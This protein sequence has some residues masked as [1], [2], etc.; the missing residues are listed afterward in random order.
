[1]GIALVGDVAKPNAYKGQSVIESRELALERYNPKFFYAHEK[2]MVTR[3]PTCDDQKVPAWNIYK[4]RVGH[5]GKEYDTIV[6]NGGDVSHY[7]R[8]VKQHDV[9]QPYIKDDIMDALI[10]LEKH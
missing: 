3:T 2:A 6:E 4:Y 1:M 8:L 9:R 7:I 5:F 10:I